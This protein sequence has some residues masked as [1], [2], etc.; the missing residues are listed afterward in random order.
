MRLATVDG[1]GSVGGVARGLWPGPGV[2][3]EACG[4]S[5]ISHDESV[6][7]GTGGQEMVTRPSTT[8]W[9]TRVQRCHS[10]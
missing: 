2:G 10:E 7:G 1:F 6:F 8:P 5:R 4:L 9:I 3:G